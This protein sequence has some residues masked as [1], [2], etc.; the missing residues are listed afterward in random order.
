MEDSDLKR[1]AQVGWLG[2]NN[3]KA[4]GLNFWLFFFLSIDHVT[5]QLF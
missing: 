4:E 1:M 5:S 2:H 3:I